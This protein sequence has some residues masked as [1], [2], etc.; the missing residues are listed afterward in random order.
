ML[1]AALITLAV[2]A[3]CGVYAEVADM[4]EAGRAW[5]RRADAEAGA[6]MS[7]EHGQFLADWNDALDEQES[8]N[9]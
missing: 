9:A 3:L 1:A 5:R 8:R 6:Q 7:W 4:M 2:L